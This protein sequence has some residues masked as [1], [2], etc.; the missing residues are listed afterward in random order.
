MTEPSPAGPF[1]SYEQQVHAAHLG[2]WVFL[3]SEALLFAGFFALYA[4]YRAAHPG[5]FGAGVEHNTRLLGAVNTV[6]LLTSSYAVASSVQA[7]SPARH[8]AAS[9]SRNSSYRA[10]ASKIRCDGHWSF[11]LTTSISI[12]SSTRPVL[13]KRP[14]KNSLEMFWPRTVRLAAGPS[15][16]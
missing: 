16:R 7:L 13:R 11:F 5:A 14:A 4:G 12:H 15:A 1:D 6:V 9:H 3:A 10:D 8:W 2:M